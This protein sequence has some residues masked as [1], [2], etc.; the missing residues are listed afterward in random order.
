MLISLISIVLSVPL[1]P[2]LYPFQLFYKQQKYNLIREESEGYAKLVVEL[3]VDREG[4]TVPQL[5]SHV[6]SLIGFFEVGKHVI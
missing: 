2:S 6:R 3:S 1:S 5:L 4:L